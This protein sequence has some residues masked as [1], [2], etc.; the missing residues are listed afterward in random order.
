MPAPVILWFR[1]DLRL[2]DNPALRAA[3]AEGP[4]VALYILDETQGVRPWGD[5]SRWWLAESLLALEKELRR[6]AVP[7]ILRR[8]PA[9]K[10]LSR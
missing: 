2:E 7:L 1:Q 5:A 3:A 9:A 8:G 6:K 10:I 4:L